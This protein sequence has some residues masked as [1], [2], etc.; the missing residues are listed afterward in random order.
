[1]TSE[2]TTKTSEALKTEAG[3]EQLSAEV[4]QSGWRFRFCYQENE[5]SDRNANRSKS[6][7]AKGHPSRIRSNSTQEEGLAFWRKEEARKKEKNCRR[8]TNCRNESGKGAMSVNC[9]CNLLLFS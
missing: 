6:R 7:K 9:N 1:M 4:S 8:R 2:K 5:T 3:S